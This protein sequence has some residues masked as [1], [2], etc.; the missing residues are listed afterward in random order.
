MKKN[1][2]LITNPVYKLEES[3][4][5]AKGR[6]RLIYKIFQKLF[7]FFQKRGIHIT[8]NHYYSP[9]PDTRTLTNNVFL[10]Q[11]KLIGIDIN[12]KRQLELLTIFENN[13]K[14][15]FDKFPRDKTKIPYQYYTNNGMF[16]GVDAETL[17]SMIRYFKPKRI[18][19]IG[20]GF[21]TFCSAQA[22]LK[23]KEEDQEI[24]CEL[25]SIEP[26]PMEIIRKGFPGLSKLIQKKIQ[27]VDLS[28]FKKLNE[29]DI[30]FIDTSH[31][32]KIGGDVQ[33]EYLEILPSLNKGVI[34]HIHDILL[35]TEYPRHFVFNLFRFWSEQYLLQAFLIYNDSFDVLW[36][37]KYM[38]L[39]HKKRLLNTFNSLRLDTE[40]FLQLGPKVLKDYSI[41]PPGWPCSFWM[42]KVK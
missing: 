7:Q 18:I 35:P 37:A 42:K 20:S 25:I 14:K 8:A 39:K 29:N 12:E 36:M 40:E 17:Y 9:I 34:V 15:E 13:Y 23:N 31:V 4:L 30:L 5:W 26:Y 41:I 32:L 21:S 16:R 38:S 33:Y 27:D 28:E 1:K 10:K 11:T 3:D 6:R 2:N 24:E 22:I 19:E